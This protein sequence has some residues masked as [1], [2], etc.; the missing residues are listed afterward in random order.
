MKLDAELDLWREQWQSSSAAPVLPDLR[1][2]VARESLFMRIMVIADILVTLVIGGGTVVFALRDPRPAT[3][4]LAAATWLFIAAAWIFGLSNRKNAWSPSA[5]TTSAFLDISIRRT[6]ANLRAVT[7]GAILYA[8]EMA[9]CLSWVHRESGA[10]SSILI[11][12][13]TLITII[14][15]ALLIIYRKKK[16]AD[17]T[18]LLNLRRDQTAAE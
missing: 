10:L 2:R 12:V 18:Y 4:I 9:F 5:S 16:R 7:F 8:V 13:I 15:A 17:L 3:A 14:L 6:R 11:F 1:K